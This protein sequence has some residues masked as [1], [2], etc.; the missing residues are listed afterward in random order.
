MDYSKIKQKLKTNFPDVYVDDD[1]WPEPYWEQGPIRAIV[2]GTDPGTQ[3]NAR[4]KYVFGL[5]NPGPKNKFFM[6]VKH[7]LDILGLKLGKIYAQNLCRNYF[8]CDSSK[9]K[10]W[11]KVA[12]EWVPYLR[13]EL[14]SLFLSEIPVLATSELIVKVLAPD[15]HKQMRCENYYRSCIIIEPGQNLLGRKLIPLFRHHRYQLENWDQYAAVV[16]AVL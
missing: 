16:R 11:H 1:N 14:D 15:F 6:A 12:A 5:E 7:N 4:F 8:N 13:Q 9:N 10:H 3:Y 2:L